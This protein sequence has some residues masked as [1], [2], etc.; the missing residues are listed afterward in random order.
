MTPFKR[1]CPLLAVELKLT[2][3]HHSIRAKLLKSHH[4]P[5]RAKAAMLVVILSAGELE[6]PS[7]A[8]LHLIGWEDGA[9]FF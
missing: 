3:Q 7:H 8:C 1:T 9:I 2:L 4:A 5:V 6:W